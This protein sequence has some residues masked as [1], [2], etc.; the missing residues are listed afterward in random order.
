MSSKRDAAH[1]ALYRILGSGQLPAS[2]RCDTGLLFATSAE[3]SNHV[4]H[5][6][7]T[8]PD[9]L[10]SARDGGP[11][12]GRLQLTLLSDA[13]TRQVLALSLRHVDDD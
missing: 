6:D 12:A 7:E 4:A 3:R 8:C 2:I 1:A 11:V 5:I 13:F 9:I 10:V